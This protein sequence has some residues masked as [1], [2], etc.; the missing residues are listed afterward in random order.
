MTL[1]ACKK[2]IENNPNSA[3]AKN[4]KSYQRTSE[5]DFRYID[6]QPTDLI[7]SEDFLDE[8]DQKIRCGKYELT[9]AFIE[10]VSVSEM[11]WIFDQIISNNSQEDITYQSV[12]DHFPELENK[13]QTKIANGNNFGLPYDFE[14]FEEVVQ[15]FV[16]LDYEYTPAI[17]IANNADG[18]IVELDTNNIL[19]AAGL[20][21]G[22][23]DAIYSDDYHS[24]LFKDGELRNVQISE[25]EAVGFSFPFF[26]T[27]LSVTYRP[28][29]GSGTVSAKTT[30]PAWLNSGKS[31]KLKQIKMFS[32]LENDKHSEIYVCGKTPM[33]PTSFPTQRF[34]KS[35][36]GTEWNNTWKMKV[37][38]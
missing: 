1:N 13:V 2:E 37:E 27:S 29:A 19:I 34:V 25:A 16:R 9:R 31:L 10:S 14:S 4:P 6:I 3:P 28:G 23:D 22:D 17:H 20:Q 5:V 7:N 33:Y 15:S 36:F 11:Q 21:Y 38:N 30:A 26:N 18:A 32:R 24:F 12:F 8:N 35:L